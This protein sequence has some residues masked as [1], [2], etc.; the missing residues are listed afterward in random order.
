MHIISSYISSFCT[1]NGSVRVYTPLVYK[2][3]YWETQLSIFSLLYDA[4]SEKVETGSYRQI[5]LMTRHNDLFFNAVECYVVDVNFVR[6]LSGF[7]KI[8]IYYLTNFI[9]L[10]WLNEMTLSDINSFFAVL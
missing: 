6:N 5:L 4:L 3:G 1:F 2:L 8:V 7:R 9:K 10:P